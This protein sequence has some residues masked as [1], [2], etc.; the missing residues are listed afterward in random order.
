[1]QVRAKVSAGKKKELFIGRD[2]YF[3]IHVREEAQRN[4]ANARV[5]ELLA[6][7]FG[8]R[9]ADV[10]IRTGHR[11]PSKTFDVAL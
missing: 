6:E 4:E 5:R 8:V 7:H 11:S 2:G 1:M 10:R 9:V 3:E